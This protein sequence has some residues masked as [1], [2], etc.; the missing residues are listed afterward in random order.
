MGTFIIDCPHC[1]AK[2]GAEHHGHVDR[3]WFDEDI[4]EP[5][6]ERVIVG[7]CPKCTL[8]LVGHAEQLTFENYDGEDRDTF[9]DVVRVYPQP[10]KVFTSD[11]IPRTV[12]A[13]RNCVSG[14]SSMTAFT[15]GAKA[16]PR[17]E[18]WP[19]IR[20]I[21]WSRAKTPKTCKRSSTPSP[22]MSTTS[23]IA[24]MSSRNA[25]LTR[26]GRAS[27]SPRCSVG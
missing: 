8:T 26:S 1:K 2:V 23:Q 15:I 20:K 14:K 7:K 22:S 25:R 16:S 12:Q 3:S 19:P 9:G 10:P 4:G 24:T 5:Q 13:L 11:R 21:S 18:T 6:G 27:R 17:C